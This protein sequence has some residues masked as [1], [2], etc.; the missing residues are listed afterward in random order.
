[1]MRTGFLDGP[2]QLERQTLIDQ[3]MLVRGHDPRIRL[4]AGKEALLV[5]DE[6]T[7]LEL[8]TSVFHSTQTFRQDVIRQWAHSVPSTFF[9]EKFSPNGEELHDLLS[10]YDGLGR[11]PDA[12]AILERMLVLLPQEADSI[13][14]EDE[15]LQTL[16]DAYLAARRLQR[17]EDGLVV[18]EKAITDFPFAFDPRYHMGM[19]LVELERGAEA[20]EHLDW[21]YHRDPGHLWL[22][23]LIDRARKQELAFPETQDATLSQL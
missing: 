18:L 22:P 23:K 9:L 15:R 17:L 5:G 20:M 6:A 12:A 8:W 10:V 19:T 21:C 1:M 11:Q 7:A 2:D 4:A 16:M 14:D 13:E 3:A